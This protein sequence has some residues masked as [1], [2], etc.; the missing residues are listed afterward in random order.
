MLN[1]SG[2][3][4]CLNEWKDCNKVFLSGDINDHILIESNWIRDG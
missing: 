1:E 3:K 2:P 4:S